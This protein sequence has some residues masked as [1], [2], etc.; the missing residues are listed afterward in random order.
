M[1]VPLTQNLVQLHDGRIGA[2]AVHRLGLLA[3]LPILKDIL[4]LVARLVG[5]HGESLGAE[6]G[7]QEE[8]MRRED[9]ASDGARDAG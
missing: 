9:G 4:V 2:D 6:A 8:E 3:R 1:G 5:G 7:D